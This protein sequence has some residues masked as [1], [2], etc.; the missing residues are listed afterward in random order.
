MAF[1]KRNTLAPD[2]WW[3]T[4]QAMSLIVQAISGESIDPKIM[5][6]GQIDI[7]KRNQ[8]RMEAAERAMNRKAK[9]GDDGGNR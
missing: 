6:P 9:R 8:D 2:T 1:A 3:S 5:I 7:E 4:A